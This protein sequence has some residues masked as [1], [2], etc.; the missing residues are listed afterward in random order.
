MYAH[1]SKDFKYIL[2]NNINFCV[3]ILSVTFALLSASEPKQ[4]RCFKNLYHYYFVELDSDILIAC[5]GSASS[6][7]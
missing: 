6:P 4:G 7:I 1:F 5:S 2:L 3:H